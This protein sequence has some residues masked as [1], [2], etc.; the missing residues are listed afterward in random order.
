MRILMILDG[1]M[2]GDPR[3]EKEGR[4]LVDAGHDVT[5]LCRAG[6][7]RPTEWNGVRL[8]YIDL[9]RPQTLVSYFQSLTFLVSHRHRAWL[10]EIKREIRRSEPD[11]LHVHDL[12]LFRTAG[13]AAVGTNIRLVLDLH[14]NYPEAIQQWAKVDRGLKA[15][16]KRRLNS[17]RSWLKEERVSTMKADRVIAV[18][19]EMKDR[20][21]QA[22]RVEPDKVVV[23]TNTEHASYLEVPIDHGIVERLEGRFVFLYSGGFG[24]HRGL[25]TALKAAAIARTKIPGFLLLLVGKGSPE[26]DRSLRELSESLSLGESVEFTGWVP[27]PLVNSYVRAAKV[28]LVPHNSNEHTDHTIPHKLFQYMMMGLPLIVSSCRPL[29][30]TVQQAGAGT[31]FSAGDE[32]ELAKRMVEHYLDPELSREMGQAGIRATHGGPYD[33]NYTAEAL[34]GMYADLERSFAASR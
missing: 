28:G 26:M 3:V 20:L 19:D 1:Q 17:Y 25:D 33:F 7:H 22:H 32:H 27:S 2:P 31:V 16:L 24:A 5:V 14:E 6:D 4:A 11:L 30:R 9:A 12:P 21:L 34:T 29:A 8:R 18:V 13:L 10:Q 15:G 23:V